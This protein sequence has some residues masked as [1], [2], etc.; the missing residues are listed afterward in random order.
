[1]I[2][3]IITLGDDMENRTEYKNQWKKEH[4]DQKNLTLPKGKL[5]EI[6]S[7]AKSIGEKS[8]EFINK[9]IDERMERIQRKIPFV[10]PPGESCSKNCKKR[11]TMIPAA[12][13]GNPVIEVP[14]CTLYSKEIV[15][16]K[17]C[18][19]CLGSTK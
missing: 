10:A 18:E 17:K 3:D 13:D 16:N 4:T 2:Y 1:M 9:A 8:N 7:C 14:L 15:D 5:T 12:E 6:E 19:E 11:C